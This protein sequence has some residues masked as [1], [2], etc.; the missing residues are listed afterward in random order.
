MTS[1]QLCAKER[2]EWM[3]GNTECEY[4]GHI[5]HVLAST[6]NATVRR[7]RTDGKPVLKFGWG[8]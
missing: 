4:G 2:V 7:A 6:V 3:G 1:T 8:A 5:T